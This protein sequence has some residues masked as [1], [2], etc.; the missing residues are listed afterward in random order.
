[1][2]FEEFYE[3]WANT[4]S[5]HKFLRD[6]GINAKDS[7]KATWD[8][9][10]GVEGATDTENT[11]TIDAMQD[12]INALISKVNNKSTYEEIKSAADLYAKRM[13]E[14]QGD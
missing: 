8:F 3:Q 13:K 10:K 4:V 1:M 2:E 6:E 14:I 12:F 5:P 7:A 9:L 11:E